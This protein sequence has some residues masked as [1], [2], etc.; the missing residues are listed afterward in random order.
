M[1]YLSIDPEGYPGT[2]EAQ[3]WEEEHARRAWLQRISYMEEVDFDNLIFP[4][5]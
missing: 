1:S 3:E 4:D 2:Q 5:R